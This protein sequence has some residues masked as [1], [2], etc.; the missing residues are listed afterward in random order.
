MPLTRRK[1]LINSAQVAGGALAMGVTGRTAAALAAEAVQPNRLTAS[2]PPDLGGPALGN[3]GYWAFADWLAGY[4]DQLWD[5]DRGYYRSGTSVNG[6]IYHNSAFLTTH[7]IA[8]LV[9]HQGD[10]R[11][12][13]RARRLARRLCDSPPWSERQT[14]DRA[15]SPVPRAGLGGEPEHDRGGDGQVDRPEG[16]RGADVRLA[17]A[18]AAAV[19]ARRP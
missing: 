9:D 5:G 8:A 18:R 10:S 2:P 6:R 16:R 15:R 12:D 14:L 13:D 17:G 19:A 11:Q 3:G 1:L 4:F 7:A